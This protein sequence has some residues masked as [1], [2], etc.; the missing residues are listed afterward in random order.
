MLR[1]RIV[2][3]VQPGTIRWNSKLESYSCWTDDD[4]AGGGKNGVTV[5]N[6]VTR[7]GV[8][9]SLTDGSSLDAALLVG[10]DGIFSTVR[11]ET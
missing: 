10:S 2:E 9:V 8:T 11:R 4:V 6:G 5:S 7:N 1:A 3:Q